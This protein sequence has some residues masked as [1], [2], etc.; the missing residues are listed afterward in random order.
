MFAVETVS[1]RV[2]PCCTVT[3]WLLYAPSLCNR[4][5]VILHTFTQHFHAP[6]DLVSINKKSVSFVNCR[7]GLD[8]YA[9]CYSVKSVKIGGPHP[10]PGPRSA[11]LQST[12]RRFL[13]GQ[14]HTRASCIIDLFHHW[15]LQWR[16]AVLT[17]TWPQGLLTPT[18]PAE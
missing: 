14:T 6:V 18:S 9:V 16:C 17:A 4:H 15:R 5:S 3:Y 1:C 13:L 2:V 10:E 11:G 7:L 12:V 8:P